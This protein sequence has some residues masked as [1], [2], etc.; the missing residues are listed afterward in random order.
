MKN[1]TPL[2]AYYAV[3]DKASIAGFAA[4]NINQPIR[5]QWASFTRFNKLTAMT[6]PEAYDA[7]LRAYY[8]E[9]NQFGA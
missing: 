9:G 4:R 3:I 5:Q 8:G 6:A 7:F 2:E 1:T